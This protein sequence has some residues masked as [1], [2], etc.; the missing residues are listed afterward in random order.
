MLIQTLQENNLNSL[1]VIKR[2]QSI[3]KLNHETL[4]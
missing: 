2:H 4:I 1:V 3:F